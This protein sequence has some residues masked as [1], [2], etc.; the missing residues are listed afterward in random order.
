MGKSQINV[1]KT[2]GLI[3][4]SLGVLVY[5]ADTRERVSCYDLTYV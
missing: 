4:A 2:T 5:W 1:G 3:V